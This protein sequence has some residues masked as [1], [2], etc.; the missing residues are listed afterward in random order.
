MMNENAGNSEL[1]SELKRERITAPGL[2]EKKRRGEKIVAVTAYDFAAARIVDKA[3]VDIALVG[4]TLGIMALG[5]RNTVPVTLD[6]TLHH[7]KAVRRGLKFALLLADMPFGTYQAGQDDALRNAV[8]LLKEGEAQAVKLEGGAAILE[9]VRR[10]TEAGIPVCGHLGLTPQS[11]HAFG[12]NKAQGQT[13]E[14]AQ[15]LLQDAKGLQ[16]AGAFAVV[17]EVIPAALAAQVTAALEIPTI[18]IG[19]GPDCDG[20]VQVWHD[21]MGIY[22]GKN[23]RHVKRYAEIGQAM[24]DALR[25]YAEETRNSAFPTQENTL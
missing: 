5:Y 10:M 15:T 8:R 16:E 9:T 18:G 22:P 17:L 23:L 6:E 20:Q 7:V 14:A 2:V 24:E 4:D 3:G 11:I 1:N 13:D 19:A 12:G 25:A 21:L